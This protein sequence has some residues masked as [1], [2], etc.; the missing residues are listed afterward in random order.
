MSRSS[1]GNHIAGRPSDDLAAD[2]RR[3]LRSYIYGLGLA[4]LLTG[5][6]FGLVYGSAIPAFWIFIAIG[7]FALIQVIVHVR[8]FLHI[9]PP[10]QKADDL[11]LMLFSALILALMA[12]GTIWILAN[13]ASR[14][15]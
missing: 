5:V 8:F 6:P 4:L 3:E 10:R 7:V 1:G 15:H 14:M 9:D 12:G 13:L 11:H 2:Y